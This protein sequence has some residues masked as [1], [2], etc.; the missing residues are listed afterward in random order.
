MQGGRSARGHEATG[1]SFSGQGRHI[2]AALGPL[3]SRNTQ[4]CLG[5]RSECESKPATIPKAG[6]Y[7]DGGGRNGKR[8]G[9][10]SPRW[11]RTCRGGMQRPRSSAQL[12][13]EAAER[14]Q[15]WWYK[16]V[17]PCVCSALTAGSHCT[18][19]SLQAP[20]QHR[21]RRALETDGRGFFLYPYEKD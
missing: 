16:A 7:A 17:P 1:E 6:S 13:C 11:E 14:D 3:L 15:T 2:P 21:E 4:T 18:A 8:Q 10:I 5:R 19:R 12:G 9:L 20:P